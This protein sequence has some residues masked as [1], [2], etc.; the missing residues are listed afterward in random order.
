MALPLVV[1]PLRVSLEAIDHGLEQ[2]AAT[3]GASP[4]HVFLR[5]T[6][7]LAVPGLVA[8]VLLG[9]ARA[10]GEFGATVTFAGSIPGETQTL[11][12]AIYAALQRTNG[13]ASAIR[14][15]VLS[16]LVSIGALL[17]AEWIN[18]RNARTRRPR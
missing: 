11:P 18:R 2:A 16:I 17:I 9:F 13:E 14:L 6:L 3:L 5:V 7:P 12:V 1:R 4:L 10:F 8:G 15:A